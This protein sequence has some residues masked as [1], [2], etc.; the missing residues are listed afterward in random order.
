MIRSCFCSVLVLTTVL[1][2]ARSTR[3][4]EEELS[5]TS[6]AGETARTTRR[7]AAADE[8]AAREKWAEAVD[9]YLRILGEAGDDLVSLDAHHS[10]QARR[11]CHLRLAALP[12]AALGLYRSRVDVQAKK[13]LEQ[14]TASRD[15]AV[16]RRLVDD[17]FCSRYT[18]Q[19]LD[20][21]G[22]LTFERGDFE[23]A[24]RWWSMLAPPLSKKERVKEGEG[25][26]AKQNRAPTLP[27]SRSL[28]LLF[29]DPQV[30]VAR[31][32]A[33][34]ILARLF[35]GERTGLQ[36]E[37]TAFRTEHATAA[38]WLAGREGVY[39]DILQR[40]AAEQQ[41]MLLAPDP[42]KSWATFGGNP[43]RNLVVPKPPGRWAR[44]RPL[45][46]PQWTVRLDTD[47]T[48]SGEPEAPIP[49]RRTSGNAA[50][51]PVIQGDRV[52]V[53]NARFIMGYSLLDGRPILRY[54]LAEHVA[55]EER[56]RLLHLKVDLP[57]EPN[58]AY[59]LSVA[60]NRV[61]ARLGAQALG[62][63]GKGGAGETSQAYLVCLDLQLEVSNKVERWKV[64]SKGTAA[65]G[66]V[67]EGGPVV[68]HGGVF[69]AESRF[70]GGQT[71][72]AISC[73]DA[74]TGRLRWQSDVCSVVQ[75]FKRDEV[76]PRY[77]HHLVTLAGSTVVYCS[78]SGAIVA[79]D[80][81]TGRRLWGVRYPSRV[82]QTVFGE[83][84]PRDLA[85]CLYS[86]GRLYVAP[87]DSDRILCLDPDTG[88]TVWESG[89][90]QVLQ[91]LG[92][93]K[94]LL[95]VTST[96]PRPCIRAL[97]AATGMDL[98]NW[99]HPAD[100]SELRT[101]GRGILAGSWV[102]WPIRADRHQGVYVL[103]QET[104]EPVLFDEGLNGNLA[105]GGGCLAVAGTG[106]L[107]VYVPEGRLLQR[108]REEAAQLRA[109]AQPLYRLAL[110]EADAGLYPSALANLDRV[111]TETG[112]THRLSA[113]L[114]RKML[115]R[116]HEM[117]LDAAEQAARRKRWEEA[118]QFLRRA[119]V[120]RFPLGARLTALSREAALRT[121]TDQPARA[122]AVWQSILENGDLRGGMI[123][124]A[125]GNPHTAADFARAQIDELI[126][127]HGPSVYAAVEKRAR[128]LL[129]TAQAAKRN[130]VAE[131]L[132][133]EFPN[134]AVTGPALLELAQWNEQ[135]GESGAAAR[136]YRCFLRRGGAEA[137]RPLAL[138]GLAQAYEPQRCWSAARSTW[139]RLANE[140][141]DQIE[142]GRS[143]R[144][145]VAEQLQKPEYQS[146]SDVLQ[147]RLV[148]PL[149][150]AWQASVELGEAE[151]GER[152]VTAPSWSWLGAG[153]GYLFSI[154]DCTII[155][156]GGLSGKVCWESTLPQK[157]RWIGSSADVVV[158]AGV[159]SLFGLSRADGYRI[160]SLSLATD[161]SSPHLEA[162]QIAG[163][164]CFLLLEE[165]R[166]VAL[167]IFS[168]SLLWTSWAPAG[169]FQLSSTGGR[170][171][172]SYC[173]RQESVL[174]QTSTGTWL[175][176]DGRT[177][178]RLHESEHPGQPWTRQP[179]F[180]ERGQVCLLTEPHRLT[181]VD[182]RTGAGLWEY[183]VENPV[184]LTGEPL[185]A[186]GNRDT[187]VVLVSR[188]YGY[189]LECLDARTGHRRWSKPRYFGTEP[190]D[191]KAGTLDESA[192][193]LVQDNLLLALA[194]I[195]GRLLWR[196]TLPA[197]YGSSTP[198]SK[199]FTH[200]RILR[201][202]E[203]LI[204][205]PQDGHSAQW[206]VHWLYVTA[207]IRLSWPPGGSLA[208]LFYEPRTGRLAQRVNLLVA[209][210][211]LDLHCHY[212]PVPAVV[213]RVHRHSS[214]A[215]HAEPTVQFCHEG[216]IIEWAGNAWGL[217]SGF[218]LFDQDP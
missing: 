159:D 108:R 177:G 105:V 35:R 103:D 191:L 98:R 140:Q 19:A 52:F 18:D 142:P 124:G 152:C 195:D 46:G 130:E 151:D 123:V 66:P 118:A 65:T 157:P 176:L 209:A 9:E 93:A 43:S 203:S 109:S 206:Q 33:K 28:T 97:E 166:M 57:A 139:Q 42:E 132:G 59:V 30:D 37:L 27:L 120:A 137:G 81:F 144:V 50:F 170:F 125:D 40:L 87:L 60:G 12:P 70:A 62:P 196:R 149:A 198:H 61:Y 96:T 8:L 21:L 44:L 88:R 89:R 138:K 178:R 126:Q 45:D 213:P 148:F 72:T 210:P 154:R 116:R 141:G 69:I 41:E 202:Q 187:L 181:A 92:V 218:A 76:K 107:S 83:A 82:Q 16:L 90:M 208:F 147:P 4:A 183:A 180:L 200:W 6:L 49:A 163:D 150:R 146:T 36:E 155:C 135:H 56:Q 55:E 26:G 86:D 145:F 13:W 174:I 25:D 80:A 74:N 167:D 84:V 17:M 212:H 53:A 110:A 172:P 48:A 24:E 175:V 169:R 199:S 34:Q 51:Y 23:E 160:W 111:E 117:L 156:R 168:G 39:A 75:D 184:S 99:L 58:L 20:L 95:I 3:A 190:I 47:G 71:Q 217:N 68:G 205:Y 119:A 158:A 100:G 113:V 185:Q 77:R 11:V 85:P 165:R 186:L 10:L 129:A 91:L 164:R 94:G 161:S 32:R 201:T 193:Y 121:E 182:S 127:L 115:V 153:N 162:F 1:V 211:R 67:F 106:K 122:V 189:Y 64:A 31:V 114:L 215:A 194:L 171:R 143:V 128:A 14:A 73:Y 216:M 2:L 207:Q 104:G 112:S 179:L 188:N 173:A 22:D 204:L 38:G 192:V 54:P 131:R 133:R 79:L 78:H 102:F 214:S 29:P 5:R 101:F 7:L 197:E 15:S 136:A 134:A 63:S